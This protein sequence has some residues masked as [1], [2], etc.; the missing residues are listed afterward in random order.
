[1]TDGQ[2][3]VSLGVEDFYY[4][5]TIAGLL[6]WGELSDERTGLYSVYAA[7]PREPSLSRVRV[8]RDS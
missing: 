6:M 8:P 7:G 1:V 2:S 5:Q 3:S 4:C